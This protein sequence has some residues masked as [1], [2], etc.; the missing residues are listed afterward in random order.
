M[1]LNLY[2]DMVYLVLIMVGSLAALGDKVAPSS[3][4]DGVFPFLR[5]LDEVRR[6]ERRSLLGD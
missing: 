5:N 6:S 2:E 1:Y 3:L 4:G